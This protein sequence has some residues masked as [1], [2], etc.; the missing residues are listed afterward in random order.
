MTTEIA[1]AQWLQLQHK[2]CVVTGAASGIGLAIAEEL[3]RHGARL[4]LLDRNAELLNRA[5]EGFGARGIKASAVACDTTSE[6]QL[7]AAAE[8]VQ[9]EQGAAQV[10]INCAGILRA[11][12]LDSMS[13]DDW[14]EVLSVNLSAYWLCSKAFGEQLRSHAT[15]GG[16]GV[17]H[18]ASIAAHFPQA[19]SGAYSA[20]KAGVC[21]LSRQIAIE[22][23]AD[24]VRSNV[25][26]PG[27]IRTPLSAGIYSHP[28]IEL[29]R[30]HMTASGRVGE[31]EDIAQ[32]AAF[33]ASPRAGYVNAA[34]LV[35]DGGMSAKLMDMVPRPGFS[36]AGVS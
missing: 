33:L 1:C 2:V 25:I 35:V 8:K 5:V 3:G 9:Q 28:G 4:V 15:A 7:V 20:A 18:V 23:G 36:P 32:V 16:A 19:Y 22:W 10:L 12:A 29:A 11:G 31:P 26:S 14:N 17:V 21:L 24:G 27:M 34:E 13:L 30:A 6:A